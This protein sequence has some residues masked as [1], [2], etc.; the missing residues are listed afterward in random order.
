[1][2]YVCGRCQKIRA[3]IAADGT[4]CGECGGPGAPD[5]VRHIPPLKH[6]YDDKMKVGADIAIWHADRRMEA[7]VV[8]LFEKV[9]P[10]QFVETGTHMGWTSHWVATHYPEVTVHTVELM[11]NYFRLSGDNLAGLPNVRR[12]RADSRA[13]LKALLPLPGVTLFWLDAHFHAD[14]PLREECRLVAKLDSYVCLI[15]D[16]HCGPDF[17]GDTAAVPWVEMEIGKDYWRPDYAYRTGYSGYILFVKGVDYVP[18]RT[19]RRNV[20][21]R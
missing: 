12:T 21:M 13:W 5:S 11:E 4:I 2:S 1:M 3:G 16:Y 18:P 19:M 8:D 17:P 6:V 7:L 15:D 20:V 10:R 9:K 14:H